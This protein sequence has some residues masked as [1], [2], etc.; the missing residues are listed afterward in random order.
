[1][2]TAPQVPFTDFTFTSRVPK[3]HS[4]FTGESA[5][6]LDTLYERAGRACA[7]K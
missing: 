6:L 4:I 1:M 2:C 3:V 7:Y 5:F